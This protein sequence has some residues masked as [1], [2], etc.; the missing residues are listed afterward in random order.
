MESPSD[1]AGAILEELIWL[2]EHRSKPV[3]EMTEERFA[4]WNALAIRLRSEPDIGGLA[5]DVALAAGFTEP[6]ELGFN[7]VLAIF[8][9]AL[10]A[11]M[12]KWN[13]MEA[14]AMARLRGMLN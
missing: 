9:T 12:V 14:E 11:L 4:I 6:S 7:A 1:L 10:G 3:Q 13:D 2:G 5:T 8:F